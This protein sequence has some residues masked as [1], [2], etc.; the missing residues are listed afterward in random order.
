MDCFEF[1]DIAGNLKVDGKLSARTFKTEEVTF[2]GA[3]TSKHKRCM[4]VPCL[5]ISRTCRVVLCHLSHV[6]DVG[7]SGDRVPR[8]HIC[9]DC[10]ALGANV[11]LHERLRP[12]QPVHS[13][14]INS[15]RLL[16][17]GHWEI[18]WRWTLRTEK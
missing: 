11:N 14:V 18:S 17:G 1:T 13:S 6:G 5:L 16:A 9:G 15:S 2:N 3:T 8:V 4:S 10:G 7:A 12:S